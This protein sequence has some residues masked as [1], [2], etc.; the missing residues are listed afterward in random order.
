MS[1]YGYALRIAGMVFEDLMN[2]Y[3]S[4]KA[5]DNR[6]SD[7][8]Q[9]SLARLS[10]Y[11]GGRDVRGL[12]RAHVRDYVRLRLAD[13]VKVSTVRR[14]LRVFCAAIN[15]V[16]LE[17][18]L[19]ELPNPVAKLGLSAEE[20]RVRWIT[21]E[22]AARLVA[23]AERVA[24]RPHLSA[25]IRLAL[26]TGCRRGELLGLEWS[27]VDVDRRF[28]LLEARHTKGRKRRT[29]PLNDDALGALERLKRWQAE[30]LS[31]SPWVFG[32]RPGSRITT[33]KTA[34]RSS[35]ERAGIDDFRIHDLRHTFASWLVMQGVS[36][37]VVKDLLGHAS[38]T[39]TEIYA[40]LAPSQGAAAV[41]RLLP[42]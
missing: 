7:R 12:K 16:R 26:N 24:R 14:E 34:W 9:Y 29:V 39:Q 2:A 8:D 28:F 27:R 10:P 38:I 1:G 37:Y 11:F 21:Q 18:D 36:L 42:F 22:E 5:L 15:F 19:H 3:L 6:S 23:A 31:G 4:A 20:P 35:L 25:F 17:H 30:R 32:W 13:G 33:F 40:H 41:Q